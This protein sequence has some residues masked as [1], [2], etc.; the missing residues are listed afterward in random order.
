VLR[1]CLPRHIEV[2][3][4]FAKG[5]PVALMQ[6]IQQPPPAGIGQRFENLIHVIHELTICKYLLACQVDDG[7]AKVLG[8]FK[9]CEK[10]WG[11]PGDS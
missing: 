1:D 11:P 3:A 10:S 5:L 6:Q 2:L 4:Q 9:R 7:R 8:V